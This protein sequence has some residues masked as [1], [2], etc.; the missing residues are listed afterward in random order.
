MYIARKKLSTIAAGLSCLLFLSG[1]LN[2]QE[3]EESAFGCAGFVHTQTAK[4]SEGEDVSVNG[5]LSLHDRALRNL[6]VNGVATLN[7]VS[8]HRLTVNG[9][10]EAS[11]VTVT[12]DTIVN[13]PLQ[14]TGSRFD[15]ITASTTSLRLE[16][17][18]ARSITIRPSAFRQQQIVTLD[19]TI[20]EGQVI[21]EQGDGRVQLKGN[22]TVKGGVVGAIE[23]HI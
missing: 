13:G 19:D 3:S 7:N 17:S 18:F 2:R 5:A 11:Q 20:V 8:L 9:P 21:F 14:A 1:C 6:T 16:H 23:V 12:G 10:I 15:A 22:A 4:S